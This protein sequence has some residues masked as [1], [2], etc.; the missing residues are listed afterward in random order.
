M[1]MMLPNE[2]QILAITCDNATSNDRMI[3]KLGARLPDFPGAPNRARCFTHVLNL[4][5]KSIMHQ[6]DLPGKWRKLSPHTDD[7]TRDLLNLAGD[8]DLEE[9]ETQAEQNDPQDRDKEGLEDDNNEGWIDE[10]SEM[11]LED[12][13]ELE[14]MVRPVRFLLTKVSN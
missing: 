14:E 1:L 10:Q 8:I 12:I 5:V 11:T 2:Y 3:D 9:Q 4:V 13:D 6:F 7:V